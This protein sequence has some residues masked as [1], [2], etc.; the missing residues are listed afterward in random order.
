MPSVDEK[1]L[2]KL[3]TKYGVDKEPV[4]AARSRL[5]SRIAKDYNA[6]T[7]NNVSRQKI[8]KKWQNIVYQKKIRAEKVLETLKSCEPG[9]N[10]EERLRGHEQAKNQAG[11]GDGTN[12][13]EPA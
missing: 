4:Q 12:F 3:V 8:V 6:I 13:S 10:A 9:P 11:A 5:W 2:A 1:L 7:D